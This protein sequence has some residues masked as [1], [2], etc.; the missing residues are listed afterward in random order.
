MSGE[1][2]EHTEQTLD[3]IISKSGRGFY[4]LAEFLHR[5]SLAFSE[6]QALATA[7]AERAEWIET[8]LQDDH[9]DRET[10]AKFLLN[11]HRDF[12]EHVKC[13]E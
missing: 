10:L 7:I 6:L 4:S 9:R 11:W 3:D 12:L 1:L 8:A 2:I 13:A 5:S